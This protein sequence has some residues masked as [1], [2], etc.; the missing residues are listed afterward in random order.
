MIH[1]SEGADGGFLHMSRDGAWHVGSI[2][3][4]VNS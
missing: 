3:L 1:D 4:G 2:T